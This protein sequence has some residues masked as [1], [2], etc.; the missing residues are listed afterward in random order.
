[1][2]LSKIVVHP[3]NGKIECSVCFEWVEERDMVRHAHTKHP[4]GD[5]REVICSLCDRRFKYKYEL[6]RH[7]NNF[8]VER[9]PRP[10]PIECDIC[11]RVFKR[12][13]SMV[14]HKKD[15]HQGP[16]PF[17]CGICDQ[18]FDQRDELRSH[19]STVHE[20]QKL[21]CDRC[22]LFF[23]KSRRLKRHID[24][25]RCNKLPEI[26]QRKNKNK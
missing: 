20:R 5:A 24:E 10:R 12:Y 25:K 26:M 4:E 8:P 14:Q 1:M 6:R 15:L 19:Q 21:S 22:G 3:K 23:T 9:H 18:Q 7:M 17:H 13:V 2:S 16:S 11:H